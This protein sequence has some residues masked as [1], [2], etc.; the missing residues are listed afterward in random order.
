MTPLEL[1]RRVYSTQTDPGP[2]PV[3]LTLIVYGESSADVIVP[4]ESASQIA[5]EIGQQAERFWQIRYVFATRVPQ[6]SET[7]PEITAHQLYP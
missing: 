2:E 5:T 1:V 4:T 6:H 7:N 3:R